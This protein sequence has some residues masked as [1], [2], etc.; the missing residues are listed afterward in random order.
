GNRQA[1]F[2]KFDNMCGIRNPT[3]VFKYTGI[4]SEGNKLLMNCSFTV[5]EDVTKDPKLM[6]RI[7]RCKD[8]DN[9][10]TC[11]PFH[12]YRA[13]SYCATTTTFATSFMK[14]FEPEWK[15]PIK[16]VGNT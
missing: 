4:R 14:Y 13:N 16:K 12:V 11:E 9:L 7:E 6:I 1:G 5:R 2:E 3:I 15:C 8:K 10:D